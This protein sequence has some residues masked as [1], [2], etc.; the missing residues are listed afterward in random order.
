MALGNQF[1]QP[2]FLEGPSHCTRP[3]LLEHGAGAHML[4]GILTG[5]PQVTFYFWVTL[6][7]FIG[8][9]SPTLQKFNGILINER[10][11]EKA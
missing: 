5:Q 4:L 2:C 9:C 10:S 6:E 8:S 11:A 1:T 7:W 3:V